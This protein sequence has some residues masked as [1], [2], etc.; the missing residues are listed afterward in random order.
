GPRATLCTVRDVVKRCVALHVRPR[1]PLLPLRP[2]AAARR[3][4]PGGPMLLHNVRLVIGDAGQPL[5]NIARYELR[6]S[7]GELSE[8]VLEVRLA[9]PELDM[10][11]VVGKS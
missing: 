6:E 11:Q 3:L 10:A 4:A 9:D 7:L 5:D 8:I 2:D 1:A